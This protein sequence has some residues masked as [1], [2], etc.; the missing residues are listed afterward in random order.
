LG[1]KV[2]QNSQPA[3]NGALKLGKNPCVKYS[4]ATIGID[5]LPCIGKKPGVSQSTLSLPKLHQF[6]L[7]KKAGVGNP[8]RKKIGN[9]KR[10]PDQSRGVS[11][12]VIILTCCLRKSRFIV[13]RKGNLKNELG[14]SLRT[15]PEKNKPRSTKKSL[16]EGASA[17]VQNRR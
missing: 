1:E 10:S 8:F 15:K 4:Q 11:V 17:V 5:T 3:L 9:A 2:G 6:L 16:L 7:K 13:F 12:E 14:R